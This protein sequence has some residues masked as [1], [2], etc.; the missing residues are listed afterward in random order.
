MLGRYC[1]GSQKVLWR[2][3]LSTQPIESQETVDR[4]Q[5]GTQTLGNAT[6]TVYNMWRNREIS[7]FRFFEFFIILRKSKFKVFKFFQFLIFNMFVKTYEIQASSA[8]NGIKVDESSVF[9]TYTSN[10][11]K[12]YEFKCENTQEFNENLSNT[13]KTNESV[14]KLVNSSIKEGKLVPVTK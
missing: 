11:D 5:S 9:V 1:E 4:P 6:E 8:I 12:E 14:G 13:L 7:L 10:I 3:W 2:R